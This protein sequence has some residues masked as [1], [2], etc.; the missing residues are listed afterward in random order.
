MADPIS[1]FSVIGGSAA[2]VLQFAKAVNDL[3]TLSDRYKRAEF[4]IESMTSNLTT[5]QW[6]WRQIG[7]MLEEWTRDEVVWQG[8]S[9]ELFIQI[10]RSLK[11]GSLVIAALEE[12]LEPFLEQLRDPSTHP[13]R[14]LEFRRRAKIVWNDQTFR[15]HQERIRDQVNSMN[16]LINILQMPQAVSRKQALDVGVGVFRKSDESAFSIVPSRTSTRPRD[17]ESLLSFESKTSLVYRELTIDSDLFTARVYKRNYR[18]P[19]IS[20]LLKTAKVLPDRTRNNASR[21]SVYSG[22]QTEYQASILLPSTTDPGYDLLNKSV[23]FPSYLGNIGNWRAAHHSDLRVNN[24]HIASMWLVGEVRSVKI[25]GPRLPAEWFDATCTPAT[26]PLNSNFFNLQSEIRK[27]ESHMFEWILRESLEI[28]QL[29]LGHFLM[30]ACLYGSRE[31]VS[32]L[33]QGQGRRKATLLQQDSLR[34]FYIH[35]NP[36]DLAFH[37]GR[38][39]IVETIL[40]YP[41]PTSETLSLCSGQLLIR[42]AIMRNKWW[43]VKAL[44]SFG[45]SI[46]HRY[47]HRQ[48]LGIEGEEE[49]EEEEQ[50]PQLIHLACQRGSKECIDILLE[51]GADVDTTDYFNQTARHYISGNGNS[52]AFDHKLPVKSAKTEEKGPS[53]QQL[54]THEFMPDTASHSSYRQSPNEAQNYGQPSSSVSIDLPLHL[55]SPRWL[56]G[57]EAEVVPGPRI[58]SH[59]ASILFPLEAVERGLI[60]LNQAMSHRTFFTRLFTECIRIQSNRRSI[61]KWQTFAVIQGLDTVYR[62][63]IRAV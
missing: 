37:H 4:M 45:V 57:S 38:M 14:S 22:G 56:V 63:D 40:E 35:E 20:D 2:L 33:M 11:G 24:I 6:A 8:D 44:L 39:D 1:I 17:T 53:R 42:R 28:P 16:L 18:N 12:D 51:A 27:S 5:I 19:L 48:G 61:T 54:Q 30:T 47:T 43:L 62:Q 32:L 36:I 52:K 59:A 10:N 46:T 3:H 60:D 58:A 29:W 9:T 21:L 23:H 15:D 31:I 49:E 7:T 13:Q 55:R 25:Q 50:G 26:E 34:S 41:R